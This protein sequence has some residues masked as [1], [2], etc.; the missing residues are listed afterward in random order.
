L[1]TVIQEKNEE[2]EKRNHSL[3]LARVAIEKLQ[4]QMQ[5]TNED[6]QLYASRIQSQLEDAMHE[7]Q[8]LQLEVARLEDEIARLQDELEEL[9]RKYNKLLK[10]NE[11]MELALADQS[12]LNRQYEAGNAH[13]QEKSSGDIQK[14]K[15]EM[16]RE[17]ETRL[18]SERELWHQ[19]RFNLVGNMESKTHEKDHLIE[20]MKSSLDERELMIKSLNLSKVD[21]EFHMEM[22]KKQ[23]ET[24]KSE[25]QDLQN[26]LIQ[27]GQDAG[28]ASTLRHRC[29]S[30]DSELRMLQE[31]CLESE[32]KL[33]RAK[34]DEESMRNE[35]ELVKRQLNQMLENM[36]NQ[37]TKEVWEMKKK[38][39]NVEAS[40]DSLTKQ[41]V[42]AKKEIETLTQRVQVDEPTIAKARDM[43]F[44]VGKLGQERDD[45]ISRLAHAQNL[46]QKVCE[47]E[48]Y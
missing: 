7:A 46:V 27:A 4:T 29:L 3:Y 12:Q 32:S 33:Q 41:L 1:R 11:Q 5:Q 6:N 9:R 30:L 28:D 31:H 42:Q 37:S 2:M 44:A 34:S 15:T 26:K 40:N 10:R 14:V 16:Q 45:L 8:R 17:F 38:L 21:M 13:D 18:I 39:Q 47:R 25:N 48:M 23:V 22:I 20:R 43:D 35:L 24:L 19:E 36:D